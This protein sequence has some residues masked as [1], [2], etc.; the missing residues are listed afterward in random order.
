MKGKY[1]L[2]MNTQRAKQLYPKI[3]LKNG[4]ISTKNK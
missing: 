4:K 1:R 2:S 3:H